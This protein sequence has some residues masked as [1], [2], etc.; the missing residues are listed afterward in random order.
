MWAVVALEDFAVLPLNR[1]PRTRTL[2][3][4]ARRLCT[5][6]A[7]PFT[8][9]GDDDSIR[10]PATAIAAGQVGEV[11]HELRFDGP[12]HRCEFRF[13]AGVPKGGNL[14][15]VVAQNDV[16][17]SVSK[18]LEQMLNGQLQTSSLVCGWVAVVGSTSGRIAS[19]MSNIGS[20][21]ASEALL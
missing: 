13:L 4:L 16:R 8:P 20:S 12:E 9:I 17:P 21:S 1:R 5:G 19:R 6:S 14:N 7:K 18:R 2:V 11:V 15:L 10:M 3:L